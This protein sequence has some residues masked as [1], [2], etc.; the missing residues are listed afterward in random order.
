[1][2]PAFYGAYCSHI[3]KLRHVPD[4]PDRGGGVA[5]SL[6]ENNEQVCS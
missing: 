2:R 5:G 1:M 6:C 4:A 3:T